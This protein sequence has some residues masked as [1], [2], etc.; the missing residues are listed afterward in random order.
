MNTN[1]SDRHSGIRPKSHTEGIYAAEEDGVVEGAAAEGDQLDNSPAVD[2][3][4]DW[5]PVIPGE[6]DNHSDEEAEVSKGIHRP[7]RPTEEEVEEQLAA[8]R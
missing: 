5:M 3:R 7:S 1:P 2:G 8:R 6:E 4:T